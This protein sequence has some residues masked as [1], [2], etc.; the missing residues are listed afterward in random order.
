MD[1]DKRDLELADDRSGFQDG[2]W[3]TGDRV[4]IGV[5]DMRS[6]A[7]PVPGCIVTECER[8]RIASYRRDHAEEDPSEWVS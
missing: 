6:I 4:P 7:L 2:R 5:R 1:Q 8:I 3:I